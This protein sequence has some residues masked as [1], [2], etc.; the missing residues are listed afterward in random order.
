V[1]L[2]V[3]PL[4]F[5][6]ACGGRTDLG[7][8]QSN[9]TLD[10]STPPDGGSN[11]CTAGIFSADQYGGDFCSIDDEW[12]CADASYHAMCSC[13]GLQ[14]CQC[15]ATNQD[16]VNFVTFDCTHVCAGE[17]ALTIAALCGF[18]H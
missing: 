11:R 14:W 12:S 16:L 3:A 2:L 10:G 5:M 8:D 6:V 17:T 9:L 15:S 7:G 4:A 13:G 1:K 18:P